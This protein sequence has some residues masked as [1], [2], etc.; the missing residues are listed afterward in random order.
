M[1]KL[2]PPSFLVLLTALVLLPGLLQAQICSPDP[3]Y[4]TPGIYPDTLPP[5]CAGEPY[6]FVMTIIVPPDTP[7][8]T[9]F[10]T[11]TV[12]IDSIVLDGVIGIP[13]SFTYACEPASCAIPGGTAGC[14]LVTGFPTTP[15]TIDLDVAITAYVNTPVGPIAQSDTTTAFFTLFINP[16]PDATVAAYAAS[17][18]GTDGA[19]KVTPT[20]GTAPFTFLW[21]NGA[22]TDSVSNLAPGAYTVD[23]TDAN[24]CVSTEAV[25]ITTQGA[26]NPILAVDTVYWD[27]CASTGGG[28]VEVSATGGT[29]TLN[30][31]WSNGNSTPQLSGLTAGTYSVT[32]SDGSGCTD[33]TT[34]QV[35]APMELMVAQDSVAN[36][37]CFGESEG[38]IGVSATGGLGTLSYDWGIPGEDGPA[39]DNLPA[40][41][42]SLNVTDEAGCTKTFSVTLTQPD[43][44][45]VDLTISGET[46][47][48]Q[49]DGFVIASASG[50]TAPLSLA[51]S[52]GATADSI[53]GLVPDTYTLTVTDAN[54]CTKVVDAEVPAVAVSIE[55][56]LD[57]AVFTVQPNP[58]EGMIQVSWTLREGR[59]AQLRLRDLRGAIIADW[60]RHAAEGS[61]RQQ[62]SLPAGLY[63]LE[64]ETAQGSS[65]RK[66]MLR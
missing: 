11:I 55:D 27:G 61:L 47:H 66:L 18:G 17:C 23:V 50:G 3:T 15:D 14:V 36:L 33:D 29:G 51:W 20:S 32:V 8:V 1:K 64:L 38:Y 62:L 21:S 22:T 54:G 44:I 30:Y 52:T 58:T 7:F 31:L 45:S 24:G 9:P 26:N 40:G 65:Y 59:E 43:S 19:A 2:F 63:L 34:L 48:M 35:T 42:Y 4:T 6:S 10:G 13:P 53:G 41:A 49:H 37:A 5:A 46:A 57:V 16:A 39:I 25:S 28:V 12:P 60:G 56:A